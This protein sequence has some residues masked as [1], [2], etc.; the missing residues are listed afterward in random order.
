[1]ESPLVR[2]ELEVLLSSGLLGSSNSNASRL[3]KFICE[4][5]LESP[6]TPLTEHEIAVEALGRRSDFDSRSDSVVRVEAHRVR[7]RLRHYY[8]GEGA[9]HRVHISIPHGGYDPTFEIRPAGQAEPDPRETVPR[10]WWKKPAVAAG[11]VALMLALAGGIWILVQARTRTR[12]PEAAGKAMM[13]APLA[14]ERDSIRILAGSSTGGYVDR[15]GHAWGADRYYSGGDAAS[16]RYPQFERSEDLTIYQTCRR[17]YDF[18]YA[19]PLRPGVYELRLHFAESSESDPILGDTGESSR[20]LMVAANGKPLL[21]IPD[22]NHMPHFDIGADADGLNVA[23]IKVFKDV[24]PGA[25]GLLRLRFRSTRLPALVNGIE[26]T[27]GLPGRMLPLH[28]R[29][30]R[31]PYTDRNGAVWDADRYYRGG[32]LSGFRSKVAGTSDPALFEG[33]RFGHFSYSIPVAQGSY[34]VTVSFAENYHTIWNAA[35]GVGT[36]RFNLYANGRPML[37]DFDVF[38]EA[39]GALR[40]ITRTFRGLTPTPQEKLVLTFEPLSDYGIV[41][42]IEVVDEG[43]GPR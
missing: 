41:N 30:S 28:W 34:T 16:V 23:D 26:I 31:T 6:N 15:A 17:G 13:P 19:I 24:S 35:P 20:P 12:Q 1:M 9:S 21:P 25:D 8:A 18:S 29:A 38:R 10:P 36:R 37:R 5:R 22:G 32:R 7:K 2:A 40:A 14:E 3:L 11:T 33:E 43:S 27:P 4:R 39:G 42:A